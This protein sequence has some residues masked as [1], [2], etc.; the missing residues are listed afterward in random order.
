MNTNNTKNKGA[1]PKPITNIRQVTSHLDP[2]FFEPEQKWLKTDREQQ[3][4]GEGINYALKQFP[5][6]QKLIEHIKGM[7]QHYC[8]NCGLLEEETQ[9]YKGYNRALSDVISFI[10]KNE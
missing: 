3:A 6:Q 5:D 4:F 9:Y 1:S 8:H 10:T 7:R 2:V